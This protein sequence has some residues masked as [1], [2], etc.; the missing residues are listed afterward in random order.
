MRIFDSRVGNVFLLPTVPPNFSVLSAWADGGS[1]S[2]AIDALR[3]SAHPTGF[4]GLFVGGIP[5]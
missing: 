3:A 5:K 2:F 1:A 4:T